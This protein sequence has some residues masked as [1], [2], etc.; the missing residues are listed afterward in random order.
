MKDEEEF[1]VNQRGYTARCN[2]AFQTDE[3][4]QRHMFNHIAE[5]NLIIQN[6]WN[7]RCTEGSGKK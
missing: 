3:H 5:D 7:L 4:M 2:M 6:A 1:T